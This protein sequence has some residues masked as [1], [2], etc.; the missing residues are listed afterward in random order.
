M[1]PDIIITILLIV[2]KFTIVPT[3]PWIIIALPFLVSVGLGFVEG[4]KQAKKDRFNK[5]N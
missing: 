4:Y 3:L 1:K 5:N 2:A